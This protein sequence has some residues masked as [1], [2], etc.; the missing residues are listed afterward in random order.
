MLQTFVNAIPC[1]PTGAVHFG[2][3]PR[4]TGNLETKLLQLTHAR[5]GWLKNR[6][7][8]KLK[9]NPDG[10]TTHVVNAIPCRPTGAVHFGSAPRSTGN[11]ETKL[12]QLTHARDGGLHNKILAQF[13]ANPH[14]MTMNI[15]TA[16]T[17]SATGAVHFRN[18]ICDFTPRWNVFR[19]QNS[20]SNAIALLSSL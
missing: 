16:I 11:L 5:D 12:L 1:H 8:L 20:Y 2:S 18:I 19:R 7:L 3:A 6:F 4:S 10:T 13:F 17:C 9:A 14:G 15:T